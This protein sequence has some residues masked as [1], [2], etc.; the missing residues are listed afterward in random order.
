[1]KTLTRILTLAGVAL[2]LI[3]A[4][5]RVEA[6]QPDRPNR[7][8]RQGGPGGFDPEQMRQRM[9]ERYREQL[10]VKGDAEWKIVE[11]R[12]GKVSEA[13]REAG[14]GMMGG[15][16]MFGGPG[17]RGGG[18][19]NEQADAQRQNRRNPFA[20]TPLP[21]AEELQKAIDGKASADELKTRLAKLREARKAKQANLV[22]A[23]DELRAILSV[24]QEA[25]AVM[26]GLLD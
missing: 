6:Q 11:E 12:I 10:E 23:Q 24:R 9:M 2:A 4:T 8:D 25:V 1:M 19:G 26:M 16:G 5:A 14:T 7:G 3:G 13:R 17:G 21:E 22:K 20:S 18:G 15:R